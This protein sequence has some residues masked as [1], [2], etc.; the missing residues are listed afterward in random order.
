MF[1]VV[2]PTWM[3]GFIDLVGLRYIG[4]MGKMGGWLVVVFFSQLCTC[5][6]LHLVVP[7]VLLD[8]R[9]FI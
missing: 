2:D 1:H 4:I 8:G 6:L 3:D 9:S 5:S 7:Y